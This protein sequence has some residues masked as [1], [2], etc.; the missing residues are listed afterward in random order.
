VYDPYAGQQPAPQGHQSEPAQY[1]QPVYDPYAGQP[2][3]QGYQPEPAQYQ[4]P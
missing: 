1:Q 2:A 4:Q 3:P